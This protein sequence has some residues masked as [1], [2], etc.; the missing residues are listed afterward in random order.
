MSAEMAETASKASRVFINSLTSNAGSRLV[1]SEMFLIVSSRAWMTLKRVP[2]VL[3]AQVFW[4][5][6]T[7]SASLRAASIGVHAVPL[8]VVAPP[9]FMLRLFKVL[10]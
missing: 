7:R 3:A 5:L 8:E 9:L 2:L 4:R 6:I 10:L 1:S